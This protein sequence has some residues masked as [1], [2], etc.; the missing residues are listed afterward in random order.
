MSTVCILY[1]FPSFYFQ[2]LYVFINKCATYVYH[3]AVSCFDVPSDYLCLLIWVFSP[4]IFHVSVLVSLGCHKNLLSTGGLTN[5]NLFFLTVLEAR[6]LRLRFQ[7]IW[8]LMR[9]LF[10]AC[11][12]MPFCYVLTWCFLNDCARGDKVISLLSFFIVQ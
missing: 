3:I 8:F 2:P 11:R 12:F 5:R 9:T 10:L 7:P 6:S 1:P 4:L